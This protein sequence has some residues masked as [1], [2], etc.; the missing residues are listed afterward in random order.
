MTRRVRATLDFVETELLETR[1]WDPA[2][3]RRPRVKARGMVVAGFRH[4]ASRDQDPQL[5]THCVLVNMTRS[6]SGEWRSV[7]PTRIRRSEKLIGAYYRNELARRLQALGMAVSPTLV[8]RIPGF[9]LAGYERSFLDAF[10]GRRRAILDHLEQ[11]EQPYTAENAQ[12]AALF[13]RRR[14]EDRSL[15]DLVPAWRARARALG[16]VREREALRPPRPLDPLTGER[17]RVPRVPA[18]DLPPNRIRSM[19]LLFGVQT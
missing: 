4:L 16:L 2:T 11:R 15:A 14:K 13:T 19:K 8:G 10:S 7:E 17:A 1:G 12:K 9:E 3:R 5:H 18:P 6:A